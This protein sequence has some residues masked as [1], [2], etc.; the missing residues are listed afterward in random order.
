MRLLV[1]IVPALALASCS[2]PSF[3]RGDDQPDL[4]LD[5]AGAGDA[6][7]EAR[8]I[9]QARS[10]ARLRESVT[11]TETLEI[12]SVL[13]AQIAAWNRGD[14]EAFMQNYWRSPELRFASGST[15]V[16]GWADALRRY[17]T[18]YPD[19][20]D[21]GELTLSDLEITIL[22]PDAATVFGRWRLAQAN[23]QAGLFTLVLRK[24]D[25]RWLIIHDHT[26][27]QF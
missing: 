2:V 13:E 19:R 17:R 26:S 18:T 16:R 23:E 12:I 3:G 20:T 5:S 6:N 7:A 11:Q 8:R 27:T 10:F 24:M 4:V 25:D 15:P 9:L 1:A 22:A 14:L 21:M